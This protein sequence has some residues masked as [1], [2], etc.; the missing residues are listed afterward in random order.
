MQ[1]GGQG[2]F[3]LLSRSTQPK[4][5]MYGEQVE[6]P[7]S[8]DV[9]MHRLLPPRATHATHP[10]AFPFHRLSGN[11]NAALEG[12]APNTVVISSIAFKPP[13]CSAGPDFNIQMRL[14]GAAKLRTR[15]CEAISREQRVAVV[16]GAFITHRRG[17]FTKLAPAEKE[18]DTPLPPRISSRL[19]SGRTGLTSEVRN[20]DPALPTTSLP[21]TPRELQVTGTGVL[22]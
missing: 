4:A 14:G 2:E 12:E 11:R 21:V 6:T 9:Q 19:A 15:R 17:G 10:N 5:G 18:D 8:Q 20:M 1:S 7:S 3:Q 16:A 22:A 13:L